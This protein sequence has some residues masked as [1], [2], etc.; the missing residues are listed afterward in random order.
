MHYI[1]LI[2]PKT[3]DNSVTTNGMSQEM[4]DPFCQAAIVVGPPKEGIQKNPS[5]SKPLSYNRC[6]SQQASY[7]Y[8]Y[9][10]KI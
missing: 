1:G 5:V 10:K 7:I 3:K 9:F 2:H 8:I 6:S 4:P